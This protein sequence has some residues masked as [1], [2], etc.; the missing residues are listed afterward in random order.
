MNVVDLLGT[1][2][3][4]V[5]GTVFLRLARR[6]WRE[7]FSYAYRMRLV[8]LPDDFK[9]GM[10]RAFAVASA[11]FYLLCATGVAVLATPSGASST[12]LWAGVLLAVLIVLVLLSVALMFAIIWFNRPRFLVPP[13]MREQPGTVGSRRR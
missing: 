8:P 9:T 6:S 4:A 10:E 7:R 5:M 1:A 2:A 13:H 3:F 11:F 12:P